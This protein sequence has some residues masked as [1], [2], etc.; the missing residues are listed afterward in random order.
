M[1]EL[2]SA[3]PGTIYGLSDHT[4]DNLACFAAIALGAS[5]VERHFTDHM[6]REG[7][8][9]VC[10]MDEQRCRELIESARILHMERGGRKGPAREEQVTMDFA[11][12]TVVTIAPIG[13]GEPFTTSNLWVKRPG[14]GPVPAERYEEILGRAAR[15]NLAADTHISM[16]D[17][18]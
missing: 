6:Q 7:P 16:D 8:D 17:V 5:I 10:S 2:A 12:A 4:T 3:F 13:A 15:R 18:V 11:F 9:I 14:T 1:T